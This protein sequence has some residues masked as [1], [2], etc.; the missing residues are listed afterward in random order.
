MPKRNALFLVV[1]LVVGIL[2][3]L[4]RDHARPGRRFAEVMAAIE[5]R[6]VEP[7]DQS[8]LFDAA[9]KG[10][11]ATLDEHSGYVT[12]D[13]QDDLNAVLDQE[14]GGVG[15]ELSAV[16]ERIVVRKP[17]VRSPAWRAGVAAGDIIESVDGMATATLGF[18]DVVRRLRGVP[19]TVVVVGVARP[20]PAARST[21]SL[22]PAAVATASPVVTSRR[23]VPL[24]RER[25]EVESVLGDR[26]L[27]DGSWNW[28]VEGEDGVA[29]LRIVNFGERTAS[30]VGQ[31][32]EAIA[33]RCDGKP[34]GLV[35][36]LRGNGGG[37]LDAAI[38]VC[39]LFLEEGVIVSTRQGSG[40]S[41]PRHAK[42]GAVS[43]EM[44]VVVLVDGFTASAAEIVAAC[45][46]DHGRA[47][48]VGSRSYG[49]GTVQSLLPLSDGSATLKLTTAEYLRPSLER[50]HRSADD[51]AA[52]PWGVSPRPEHEITPTRQQADAVRAWREARDA[53]LF[54]DDRPACCASPSRAAAQASAVP[55]MPVPTS[56]PPRESDP[57]L[58]RALDLL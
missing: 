2:G 18:D 25:I 29:I 20:D 52:T 12:G 22:D 35:L 7:V 31:A 27:P 55:L 3:W 14:F 36:D 33:A 11:F 44:P 58:A 28:W 39:D 56:K 1:S 38:D 49:K 24:T 54:P 47:T 17:I 48:V 10:V 19:G 43:A 5:Q 45:L 42:P 51:G 53:A 8:R 50:I 40:R 30:E 15:L 57:V 4:T 34:R 6:Y 23:D 46:Q 9:M 26:R 13:E 41:E 21:A 32:L 37:L 16:G